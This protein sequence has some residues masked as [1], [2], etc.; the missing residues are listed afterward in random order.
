MLSR[1][2]GLP[3]MFKLIFGRGRSFQQVFQLFRRPH[4]QRRMFLRLELTP[5][6]IAVKIGA[7]VLKESN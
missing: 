3:L 1:L 4:I 2:E 5:I 7:Q 6:E